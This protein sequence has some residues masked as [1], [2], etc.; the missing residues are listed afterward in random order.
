MKLVGLFAESDE[1]TLEV[2]V[3]YF[4]FCRNTCSFSLALEPWST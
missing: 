1:R 3:I 2:Q 4:S